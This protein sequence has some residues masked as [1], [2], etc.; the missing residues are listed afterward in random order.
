MQPILYGT[1]T[2]YKWNPIGPS[3]LSLKNSFSFERRG[4]QY[5]VA[6]D[7]EVGGVALLENRLGSWALIHRFYPGYLMMWAP[8]VIGYDNSDYVFVCDTMGSTDPEWWMHMRICSF[9]MDIE[10]RIASDFQRIDIPDPDG[11]G[12]IDPA[13]IQIGKWWYL[14]VA[15]LWNSGSS[16]WWDPVCYVAPTPFGPYTLERS[17]NVDVPEL[18]IDEAF[19]PFRGEGGNLL[20]TW[21]SGD[22]GINGSAFLGRLNVAHQHPEGWYVFKA[23]KTAEIRAIDGQLCTAVDPGM[24]PR[25]VATCRYPGGTPGGRDKFYLAELA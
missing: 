17:F 7:M 1:S 21:S 5:M 16:E 8:Y 6:T 22:S 10:N 2:E 13:I 24:W 14:F 11:V 20:C 18:G 9:R 15:D 19:K 12:F 3:S 25:L 23:E 4:R